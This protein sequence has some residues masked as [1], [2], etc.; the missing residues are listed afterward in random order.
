ML[1][2]YKAKIILTIILLIANIYLATVPYNLRDY[3]V[4]KLLCIG[5]IFLAASAI[6][7]SYRDMKAA[8]KERLRFDK[9]IID[10][11][12]VDPKDITG[13]PEISFNMTLGVGIVLIIILGIPI[14]LDFIYGPPDLA[15]KP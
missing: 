13:F 6:Y 12:E 2:D 9:Y 11:K 8:Q 3:E 4:A 1:K 5:V 15:Y 10:G 7:Q 14:T